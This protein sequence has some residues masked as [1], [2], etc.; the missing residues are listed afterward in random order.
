MRYVFLLLILGLIY[1]E[2][3]EETDSIQRAALAAGAASVVAV[4]V[5]YLVIEG[6]GRH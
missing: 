6:V 2:I 5:V 3:R 1:R 4:A